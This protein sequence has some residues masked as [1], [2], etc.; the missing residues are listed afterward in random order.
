M[1]EWGFVSCW[2]STTWSWWR[3]FVWFMFITAN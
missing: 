2:K 1:A 3:G